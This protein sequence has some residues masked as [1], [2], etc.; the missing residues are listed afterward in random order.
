[1]LSKLLTEQRREQLCRFFLGPCYPIVAVLLVGIG[2]FT[3]WEVWLLFLH[4]LLFSLSLLILPSAKHSIVFFATLLYQVNLEHTPGK[5]TYSP[6]Y[7]TGLRLAVLLSAIVIL[8]V[9]L[10]LFFRRTGLHRQ[11]SLRRTSLLFPLLL[12]SAAFLMNGA[13][14]GTSGVTDVLIGGAQCLAYLGFFLLFYAG[15]TQQDLRDIG[16]YLSYITLLIALLLATQLA[17]LYLTSDLLIQN[18]AINK[19]AMLI[20]WGQIASIGSAFVVLLP[21][22]FYGAMTARRAPMA[23]AY[24]IT[25]TLTLLCCVLTLSRNALL[26]GLPLYLLCLLLLVWRGQH[27]RLFRLL[28]LLLLAIGI[29]GVLLCW[30][31]IRRLLA[32][33]FARGLSDNGRFAIYRECLQAFTTSPIFGVGFTGLNPE[34]WVSSVFPRFAHNTLL[35]MLCS[36]GV[37]GLAAYLY[38]RVTTVRLFCQRPT[39]LKSM[40]GLSLLALLAGGMLDVFPFT[41]H[42]M[43]YYNAALAIAARLSEPADTDT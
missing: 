33:S 42:P 19:D 26:I 14:T 36:T 38:Y 7:T 2:Y 18:G 41:V 21:A 9:C 8:C 31:G 4:T 20:G 10:T 32:D 24:F 28:S 29:G 30:D 16:S 3:G 23:L 27:R 17:A 6:Y 12:L 11:V 13:F 5:P 39:L 34:G 15:L 22:L 37:L 1:M 40:L 35:Q 43:I 25:A